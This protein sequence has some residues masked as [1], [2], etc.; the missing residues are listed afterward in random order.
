MAK[1]SR[2][3]LKTYFETGDTPSESQFIDLIDS[4]S[5]FTDDIFLYHTISNV[6]AHAG[7]GQTD[8]YKLLYKCAHVENSANPGDSVKLNRQD[9]YTNQFVANTSGN[10]IDVFPLLGG[11]IN[12]LGTNNAYALANNTSALFFHLSSNRWATVGAL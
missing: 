6:T 10:S 2:T 8:A 9:G 7:G 1:R 11:E 4:L 3:Q 5:D 12:N